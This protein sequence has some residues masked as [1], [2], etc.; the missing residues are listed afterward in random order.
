MKKIKLYQVIT[1]KLYKK[2]LLQ[3]SKFL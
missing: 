3:K 2:T 1:I